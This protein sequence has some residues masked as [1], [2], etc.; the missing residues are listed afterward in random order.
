M[1]EDTGN[2]DEE[3]RREQILERQPKH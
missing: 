2:R 1:R 3:N